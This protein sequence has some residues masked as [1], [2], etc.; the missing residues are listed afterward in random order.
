MFPPLSWNNVQEKRNKTDWHMKESGEKRFDGEEVV[1]IDFRK[2]Q[3]NNPLIEIVKHT[4][5]CQT[6]IHSK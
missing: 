5:R 2:N 4:V 1:A 3:K 6:Q